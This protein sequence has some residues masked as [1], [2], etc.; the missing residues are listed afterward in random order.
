MDF[1]EVSLHQFYLLI[2]ES[3]LHILLNVGCMFPFY[4]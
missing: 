2:A 3:K 1:V 4:R